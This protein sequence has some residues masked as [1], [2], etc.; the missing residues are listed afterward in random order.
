M[1]GKIKLFSPIIL[2]T[3]PDCL[4]ASVGCSAALISAFVV[5]CL[6]VP[7]RCLTIDG[8]R[9]NTGTNPPNN[10]YCASVA[11][12][13][14]V[15]LTFPVKFEQSASLHRDLAVSTNHAK[16]PEYQW[17]FDGD[18]PS[19]RLSELRLPAPKQWSTLWGV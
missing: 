19:N 17:E 18:V 11:L 7:H 10:R 8:E 12:R 6:V 2:A 5:G 9:L 4:Y 3:E 1:P 15:Q 16:A 13:L 14:S